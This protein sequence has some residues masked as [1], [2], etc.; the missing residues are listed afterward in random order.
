MWLLNY[1][2]LLKLSLPIFVGELG[3]TNDQQV[4]IR[5]VNLHIL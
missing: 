2:N 5:Q 4:E 3:K 1:K